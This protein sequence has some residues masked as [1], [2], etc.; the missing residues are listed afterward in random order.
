[1]ASYGYLIPF[2]GLL[3]RLVCKVIDWI[4]CINGVTCIKTKDL[5]IYLFITY[6]LFTP[7]TPYSP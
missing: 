6:S 1:M 5:F 2:I 3:N 4:A 7:V